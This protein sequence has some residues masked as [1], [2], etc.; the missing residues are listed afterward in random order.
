MFT[1]QNIEGSGPEWYI[2]SMIYSRDIIFWLELSILSELDN[3]NEEPESVHYSLTTVEE[4][5]FTANRGIPRLDT[6][7]ENLARRKGEV[8]VRKTT[9]QSCPGTE[10]SARTCKSLNSH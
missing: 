3:K 10:T 5:I 6:Y 1:K 8:E 7:P 2:S 4:V 9:A